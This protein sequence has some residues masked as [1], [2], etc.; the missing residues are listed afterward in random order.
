MKVRDYIKNELHKL[1]AL[2]PELKI[3]LEYDI[4]GNTY[5]I[6]ILPASGLKKNKK[7]SEILSN[8]TTK[9]FELYPHDDIVFTTQNKLFEIED[10]E[11]VIIGKQ[12]KE[13]KISCNS[14]NFIN[15][16]YEEYVNNFFSKIQK[17]NPFLQ[18]I[19]VKPEDLI[20]KYLK[21][22][23]KIFN[24][25]SIRYQ[26]DDINLSH[27]IEMIDVTKLKNDTFFITITQNFLQNFIR[28]FPFEEI[29]FFTETNK[30]ITNPIYSNDKHKGLA[31]TAKEEEISEYPIHNLISKFAKISEKN[32]TKEYFF[33]KNTEIEHCETDEQFS[34]KPTLNTVA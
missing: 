18:H 31:H 2:F 20:I 12:Y 5:Y 25:L 23:D 24:F 27:N 17:Y 7:L 13:N 32:K 29:L 10:P 26:Y 14:N 3:S 6:E 1:S 21:K 11:L 9:F 22:I 33:I 30:E 19:E 15:Q 28:V 34:Y 4:F 16:L 8:F